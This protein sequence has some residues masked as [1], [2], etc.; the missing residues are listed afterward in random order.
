M[1]S[2]PVLKTGA[3]AQYPAV[4]SVQFRNQVLRFVDGSE[5]RFRDA[6]SPLHT[7]VIR[8][9]NLDDAEMA[10][11]EGFFCANNGPLTSFTFTDPWSATK[12]PNCYI[13]GDDL[14]IEWTGEMKSRTSIRIHEGRA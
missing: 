2:F 8:L 10:A 4:E 6:G 11:L 13:D 1:E 14:A 12:Y 3:V 5:Q 7:W 9:S